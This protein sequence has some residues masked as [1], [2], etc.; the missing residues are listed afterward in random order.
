MI[1]VHEP[2]DVG[3]VI[4]NN[5]EH[6]FAHK[7]AAYYIILNLSKI[8]FEKLLDRINQ[9]KLMGPNFSISLIS[10]LSKQSMIKNVVLFLKHRI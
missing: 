2:T 9:L 6:Q 3:S 10:L 8:N 4:H 1:A 5:S 7:I